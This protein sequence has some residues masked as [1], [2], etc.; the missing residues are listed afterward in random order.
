MILEE[1]PSGN[2][3]LLSPDKPN[4]AV[5]FTRAEIRAIADVFALLNEWRE[6]AS[7]ASDVPVRP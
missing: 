1:T 3:R 4:E 5:R 6:E 7:G 2:L